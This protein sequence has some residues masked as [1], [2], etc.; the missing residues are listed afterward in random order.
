M[1]DPSI[2][3]EVQNKRNREDIRSLGVPLS[4][5]TFD[6]G[7]PSGDVRVC[8]I[9]M[10]FSG[11]S[12]GKGNSCHLTVPLGMLEAISLP[13]CLLLKITTRHL[14]NTCNNTCRRMYSV[15]VIKISLLSAFS[16]INIGCMFTRSTYLG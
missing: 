12:E 6:K 10:R 11:E 1:G 7:M 13:Y 16:L 14:E 4:A 3:S 2:E 8:D 9:F 5:G 15:L